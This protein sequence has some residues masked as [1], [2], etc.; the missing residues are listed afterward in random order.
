MEGILLKKLRKDPKTFKRQIDYQDKLRK[1]N[2]INFRSNASQA[3]N[4]HLVL[5][6]TSSFLSTIIGWVPFMSWQVIRILHIY[7][8]HKG[9]FWNNI[10]Y[11]RMTR[12][13]TW[14]L[15]CLSPN[16]YKNKKE[17]LQEIKPES[18]S[19]FTI[20]NRKYSSETGRILKIHVFSL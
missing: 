17:Y 18:P 13:F 16:I 8:P 14:Y 6:I 19:R 20:W 12:R 1:K 11:T 4:N 10:D 9:K 3:S 7:L 5:A 2:L 15:K